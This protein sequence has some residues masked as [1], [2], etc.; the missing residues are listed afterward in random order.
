MDISSNKHLQSCTRVSATILCYFVLVFY[1]P[2]NKGDVKRFKTDCYQYCKFLL[3][4]PQSFQNWRLI[5]KYQAAD[6]VLSVEKLSSKLI[7][8]VPIC[9]GPNN[10]LIC[11]FCQIVIS[12]SCICVFYVLCVVCSS[13]FFSL[14][15]TFP[16][17]KWVRNKLLLLLQWDT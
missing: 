4:L 11:L 13:L 16:F 15:S 2:L 3:Y 12:F 14:Y 1:M 8:E 7:D 10:H 9:F 6:I 17:C 5:S